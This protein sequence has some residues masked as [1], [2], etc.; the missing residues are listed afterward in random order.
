MESLIVLF[1]RRTWWARWTCW[2]WLKE[3]ARGSCWPVPARFMEILCST[4]RR[5]LIGATSIPL[6]SLL[7]HSLSSF[8][9]LRCTC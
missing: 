3:L 4:L 2:G 1:T 7:S 6:V 5:R 8:W 9:Y